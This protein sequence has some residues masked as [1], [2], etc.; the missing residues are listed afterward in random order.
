[1]KTVFFLNENCTVEFARY[2]HNNQIAIKLIC[3]DG[4]PMATATSCL[5]HEIPDGMAALKTYSE[6]E[7]IMEAL[8]EAGI[9]RF[10]GMGINNGFVVFPLV[11]IIVDMGGV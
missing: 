4:S 6:N 2:R 3:E 5:D 8:I 1:M 9:V 10:T 11:E 7:G